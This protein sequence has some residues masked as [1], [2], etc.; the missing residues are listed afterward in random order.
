MNLT[1]GATLM[2]ILLADRQ[3]KVRFALR[4]LLE[5]KPG[6]KIVGE[7][8][9]AEDLLAQVKAT[10]PD[11]IMLDWRLRNLAAIDLMP[12]LRRICPNVTVIVLSGQ[13][14]TRQAALSAGADAFVSKTSSP[15][16]VLATINSLRPRTWPTEIF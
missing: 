9:D 11:L 4:A 12:A 2:R 6:I 14:E 8:I 3:P 13:P 5:Q 16:Q 1:I 10:Q 7:A 15:D